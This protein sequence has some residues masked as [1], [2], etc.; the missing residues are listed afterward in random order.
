[1]FDDL[2]PVFARKPLPRGSSHPNTL[3]TEAEAN[4][5]TGAPGQTSSPT[6]V[7]SASG[8]TSSPT[9]SG[10]DWSST[11]FTCPTGYQCPNYGTTEHLLVLAIHYG[12][13]RKSYLCVSTL[14]YDFCMHLC[15]GEEIEC[16]AS[17]YCPHDTYDAYD[18]PGDQCDGAYITRKVPMAFAIIIMVLCVIPLLLQPAVVAELRKR[19]KRTK[20]RSIGNNA[21][22]ADLEMDNKTVAAGPAKSTVLEDHCASA[23]EARKSSSDYLKKM[24]PV[25]SGGKQLDVK[26][27][28]VSF[29]TSDKGTKIISGVSG[30]FRRGT[31][32]G[33][34]LLVLLLLLL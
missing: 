28:N 33:A 17:Q 5:P 11:Y 24:F 3:Q 21:I 6:T 8:Q 12:R 18:C 31:N 9:I 7:A 27:E 30:H 4:V 1:M 19:T 23:E 20:K 10:D 22:Y 2:G 34:H 29:V 14:I 25:A 15:L 26:F 32:N 16:T 13:R